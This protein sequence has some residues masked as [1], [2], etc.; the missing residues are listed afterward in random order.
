M[1]LNILT[2]IS[3]IAIMVIV[4]S[5]FII[6]VTPT[7]SRGTPSW[8]VASTVIGVVGGLLVLCLSIIARLWV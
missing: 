6:Q 7:D 8:V 2:N 5:F 3:T 1:Y 4:I